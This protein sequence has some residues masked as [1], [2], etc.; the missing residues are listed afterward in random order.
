MALTC[1]PNTK[2]EEAILIAMGKINQR[3][4]TTI[5][6]A[7]HPYTINTKSARIVMGSRNRKGTCSAFYLFADGTIAI[8][9]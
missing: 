8:F 5:E 4:G 1:L 9:F 2:R 3:V 6:K 7:Y